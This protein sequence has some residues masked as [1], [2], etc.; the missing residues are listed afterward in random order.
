VNWS[1]KLFQIKGID[2][3]IHLTFVLI[4]IWV[5]YSWGTAGGAGIEG[6]VFGLV[7]TILL[8]V[9]ITLHELAHSL[10]ALRYGIRVHDILLLPIGG[11]SQIE[12]MPDKPGQELRIALAGPLVSFAISAA[13][14]GLLFLAG[15]L[16]NASLD[17]SLSSI[18]TSWAG[19][20]AY[21]AAANLLLG[22]FNI[23]PAFPM[24]GG[25]I[26]RALLAMRL[27]YAK[28]TAIA[29]S[30]GQALAI[31]VGLAGFISGNFFLIL[32][33]IFVWLGAGQEGGAVRSRG[34][35]RDVRV[36]QAMTREPLA[37]N[38]DDALSRAIDLTLS[39][40]QADFPVLDVAG[41]RVVGLLTRD[42][43]LRGLRT[44][45]ATAPV[46]EAMR[47]TFPT[48]TPDESLDALQRRMLVEGGHVMPVVDA[49][50]RLVGLLTAKDVNEAFWLLSAKDEAKRSSAP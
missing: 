47:T 10:V 15:Q 13:L 2:V 5:A 11:V 48:A 33:A 34:V 39:S 14:F 35:L 9:C 43:V 4:L 26:L 19:M 12:E 16:S 42:G 24:D 27:E 37:L 22:L 7:A 40:E 49:S 18:S 25:R 1:I 28:A 46:S 44:H 36:G 31:A 30:I 17:L 3:K 20:L 8:F 29:A 6:A 23:L 32:I 41:G 45:G 21:L 38:V 50:G